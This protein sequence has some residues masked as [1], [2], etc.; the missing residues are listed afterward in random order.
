MAFTIAEFL[1]KDDTVQKPKSQCSCPACTGLN[2]LQ[3]PRFFAGQL[4][5]D[6][7]LN[8]EVN[9]VL[10]KQRLHN[11]YL[12]GVGTVCGLE[13]VCS[14]CDGQVVIKPGYAIDPCGNDIIVCQEQQFD[15]LKAIKACCDAIKKKN[16]GGCDPYRPFNEGCTGL[17]EHWCITIAY[18]ELQTQPVT[19]LHGQTKTCSCV[20]SCSPVGSCG[21]SS[22]NGST[23][24]KSNG[25]TPPLKAPATP[26]SIACE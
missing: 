16:K 13:V 7:D 11:R 25:C 4:I 26:A 14:N 18:Q 22:C 2:C 9:Y 1:G 15:V 6:V 19:P 21:C 23:T 10:A 20:G 12:H 3:R 5:S 17:E 8:S 24:T